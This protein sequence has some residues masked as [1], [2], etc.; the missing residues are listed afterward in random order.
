MSEQQPLVHVVLQSSRVYPYTYIL[1]IEFATHPIL[2]RWPRVHVWKQWR[3]FSMP[4]SEDEAL[5][6]RQWITAEHT[7]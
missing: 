6:R 4:Y 1:D 5:T 7:V 3:H 2:V